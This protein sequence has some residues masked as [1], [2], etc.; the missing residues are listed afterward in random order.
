[1]PLPPIIT[2]INTQMPLPPVTTTINTQMPL[3]P[4]MTTINTRLLPTP[5]VSLPT[6]STPLLTPIST[7][8]TPIPTLSQIQVPI[9]TP[10]LNPLKKIKK[11]TTFNIKKKTSTD[12]LD[13]IKKPSID[14]DNLYNYR[15]YNQGPGIRAAIIA[16][17]GD[18]KNSYDSINY[19]Q[20]KLFDAKNYDERNKILNDID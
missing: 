3:P 7:S 1:M 20:N 8:S 10:I 15:L 14:D 11:S 9:S 19:L 17:E 4:I 18:I 16:V 5:N 6:I 2:T 12:P 13:N